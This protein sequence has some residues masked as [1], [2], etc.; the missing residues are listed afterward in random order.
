LKNAVETRSSNI[1][2]LKAGSFILIAA[3][4]SKR[5]DTGVTEGVAL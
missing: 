1:A 3:T 5:F 2:S 4:F